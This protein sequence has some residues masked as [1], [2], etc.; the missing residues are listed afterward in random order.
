MSLGKVF[1]ILQRRRLS[2]RPLML[3]FIL[4]I[5]LLVGEWRVIGR[6]VLWAYNVE[7]AGQLIDRGLTWPEPRHADTLPRVSDEEA[8]DQALGHLGAAVRW[9]PDHPHAYRLAGRIYMARR[10]WVKTVE[11]FEQ[12]RRLAPRH[13]M[14]DWEVGLAYEQMASVVA[15]APTV[16]LTPLL[17]E[18]PVEAPGVPVDTPFCRPGKPRTCYAGPATFQLPYAG[19]GDPTPVE[20]PV[21]FLH[22]PAKVRLSL[23]VPTDQTA[24][25][26]LL[27]LDPR[28]R[29]WGTDG[30]T[31]QL[32]V[33]PSDSQALLLFERHVTDEEARAGWVPG[34]ADLTP[35]AGQQVTLV[36]GTEAGPSGDATGDWYGWGDV[37]LTT[38]E[39]ARYAALAPLA[40]M[41]AAWL[42]GGFNGEIMLVRGDE[43]RKAK[44]YKEAMRWYERAAR[45]T[46]QVLDVFPAGI[47]A[48][49]LLIL[50][51]FATSAAWHPCPWCRNTEGSFR[52]NNGLA[53][54]SYLNKKEEI[55][56]F[57]FIFFPDVSIG[58]FDRLLLRMK[59]KPGTLLT[60]E[61]VVDGERSRPL[62]YQPVPVDWEVWSIPLRGETLD[63]VL[64]GI[65]EME[66]VNIPEEYSLF[67]DWIALQ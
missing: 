32:W 61:I 16:P 64:I 37:A 12:A 65:G 59:G 15:S 8:L 6:W 28:A 11:A 58:G 3:V 51:S 46:G 38:P 24:L 29:E 36:F 31:F 7:R 34:W 53:E 50:E 41:R 19:T 2:I 30:A 17:A 45:V 63:E 10:E 44:R 42:D 49:S 43:A 47:Q 57:S 67:I 39:A 25:R 20:H 9:R 22:P 27:G 14:A 62:N 1:L 66:S 54:M 21:L 5:L 52:V 26:F 35:W 55:Q 56:E 33:E 48:Q 40:R 18:A 23:R 13:P 60:L 4:S